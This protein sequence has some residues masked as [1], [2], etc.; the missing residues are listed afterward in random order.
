MESAEDFIQKKQEQIQKG[1]AF[2]KAKDIGRRGKFGFKIVQATFMKQHNL[3]QKVFV[4]ER[5]ERNLMQGKLA[6]NNMKMGDIEYRLGYYIVGKNG[7]KKGVWTWG[8]FC[9]LIPT[10]DFN[11]L[12]EKAKK[13]GTLL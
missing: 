13:E 7:S 6:Y 11:K 9:P 8:Q 4:L 5:L 2:V 3:A 1:N 12:I 10:E